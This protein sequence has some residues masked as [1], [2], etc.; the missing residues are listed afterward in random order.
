MLSPFALVGIL[1]CLYWMQVVVYNL[2]LH[3][4]ASYPG[5]LLARSSL[6][7][8]FYYTLGGRFHLAIDHGHK[9]YGSVFRVSPNELSFGSATSFKDIYGHQTGGK[10]IPTKS[11]FYNMYGSGFNSLCIGSERDPQK[12][13]RMKA[14]LSAAFSTKALSEQEHIVANA[15]DGFVN[16]LGELGGPKSKGV[17]ITKWYEM[18]A[19]DV[20]GE[21]AFGESFGCVTNGKPHFWQELIL[22]HLYLI[23][24]AD[25]LRRLPSVRTLAR[26]FFPFV[27]AI[28]RKHT[29][30]TREKVKERLSVRFSRNDFMTHLISK[31]DNGTITQEELTAHASTLVIAGGETVAT[32]LAATTFYL[33]KDQAPGG[34]WDRLCREVRGHYQ[35]YEEIDAASAQQ[36]PYLRAVIEEGLRIYPPGSQG[37][38]RIS[39][40]AM[41]DGHWVPQGT[42]MYTSAFTVT[43]DEK[44]FPDPFRFDPERWLDASRP[45]VKEASQP[46]SLGPRGCLGRNFAL[47][48]INQILAKLVFRYDWELVNTDLDWQGQSHVH[49][50]WWKPS[51]MVRFHER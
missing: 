21:M 9:Q 8:R 7:W 31:V 37:F 17:D 27:S 47:M 18:I 1:I 42:E 3:P 29:G 32:F 48:E 12:H 24:V 30:Y 41:I 5:P 45:D 11:E 2:Y 50:M 39:P 20:L 26:L 36:L 15:V 51:L 43:H 10:Q 22:E 44:N 19:F 16:R 28:S 14:S 4:L 46:F 33:L 13:R 49:V 35:S 6:I 23:T 40:G 38:P 25:N 34:S